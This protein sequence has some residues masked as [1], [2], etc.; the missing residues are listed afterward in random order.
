M[1]C[2]YPCG[3][4]EGEDQFL[5]KQSSRQPEGFRV[6]A[7]KTGKAAAATNLDGRVFTRLGSVLPGDDHP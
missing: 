1:D 2:N 6:A 3:R 5:G 7:G 4:G